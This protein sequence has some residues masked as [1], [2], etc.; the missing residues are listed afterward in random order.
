MDQAT[1]NKIDHEKKQQIK[2]NNIKTISFAEMIMYY[3]NQQTRPII[4][5][6][7]MKHTVGT[8]QKINSRQ[9]I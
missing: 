7:Q 4:N 9:N 8:Y 5:S 1:Q 6:F 3:I 2:Y